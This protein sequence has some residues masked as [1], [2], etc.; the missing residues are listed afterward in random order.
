MVPP[1]LYALWWNLFVHVRLK[2]S[3]RHKDCSGP[4]LALFE[5]MSKLA[6]NTGLKSAKC[7]LCRLSN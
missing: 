1:F 6:K 2:V 3:S 5:A 7:V 4:H